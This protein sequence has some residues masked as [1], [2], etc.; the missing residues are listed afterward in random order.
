MWAY[1]PEIDKAEHLSLQW[2]ICK[3]IISRSTE[4]RSQSELTNVKSA[5]DADSTSELELAPAIQ[6][7]RI[8]RFSN[9]KKA[10]RNCLIG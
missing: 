1:E 3:Y 2:W 5:L 4:N 7:R 9:I 6:V 10:G 8:G